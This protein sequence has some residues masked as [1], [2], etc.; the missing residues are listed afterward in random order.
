MGRQVF[1]NA[2]V[3]RKLGG[4]LLQ[5][6]DAAIDGVEWNL[7]VRMFEERFSTKIVVA[8][9]GFDS[10]LGAALA[11][12]WDV[13]QIRNSRDAH[14]PIIALEDGIALTPHPRNMASWPS[15]YQCLCKMVRTTKP[16]D[17]QAAVLLADVKPLLQRHW[18]VKIDEHW[19]YLDS[20]G[21]TT[22]T[23]K[24]KHLIQSILNWRNERF[25]K[26]NGSNLTQVDAVLVDELELVPSNNHN[27]LLLRLVQPMD[28]L[29]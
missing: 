21:A 10:A 8:S 27:D 20:N 18:H 12:L 9:M 2:S 4:L 6:P 15:V 14:N 28:I 23:K 3:A 24:M 5:F 25:R 7:L 29:C 22:K 19:D 13:G 11:L 26:N 17:G 1:D 16:L